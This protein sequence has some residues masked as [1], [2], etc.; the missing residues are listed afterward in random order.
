VVVGALHFVGRE[1]L[2]ALLRSDGHKAV[3]VPAAKTP[4]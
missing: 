4:N 2:L 3:A 1:G